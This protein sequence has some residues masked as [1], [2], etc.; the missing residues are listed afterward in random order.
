MYALSIVMQTRDYCRVII[1]FVS[2]L[3]NFASATKD[4]EMSFVFED[5]KILIICWSYDS[6]S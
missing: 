6:I 2:N 4:S 5:V 3:S 1:E